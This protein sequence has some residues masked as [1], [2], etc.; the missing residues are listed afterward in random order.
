MVWL[1]EHVALMRMQVTSESDVRGA[2][3]VA[4]EKYGG[5]TA[6]VNCA[7]I[8][9]AIRTLS[10]K[11]PHPLEHFQVGDMAT[12]TTVATPIEQP[13]ASVLYPLVVTSNKLYGMPVPYWSS[14]Q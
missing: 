13:G 1:I 6:A 5:V 10:K 14:V 11:G 9:V 7:G 4:K 3:E 12:P 8:G 2:L